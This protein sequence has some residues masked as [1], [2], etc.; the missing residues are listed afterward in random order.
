[1]YMFIGF[2][3]LSNRLGINR[4]GQPCLELVKRL[5]AVR[6]L[7]LLRLVHF[8]VAVCVSKGETKRKEGAHVCPAGPSIGS[9]MASQPNT[10]GP[11]GLTMLPSVEP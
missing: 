6:D 1:M 3:S 8:G 10:V 2:L 7:V 4:L 11:L 5:T 9:K